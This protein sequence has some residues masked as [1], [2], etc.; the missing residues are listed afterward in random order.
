[1]SSGATGRGAAAAWENVEVV[2]AD[3]TVT[4]VVTRAHLRAHNLCHRCVYIAVLDGDDQLVVHQRAPWKDVWPSRW[5][6]AFGGV[7]GVGETWEAAARRELAEEAGLDGPLERLGRGSYAD[8]E[9]QVL[10]EAYLARSNGPFRFDDG[11]VVAV[12]RIA[13][14]E[15]GR[16][17]DGHPTCPDS[18]AVVLPL[19]AV[20][21]Q[22]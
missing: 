18:V 16:W 20:S 11:E 8:A 21:G 12:D 3:G 14:A 6:V 7:V 15:L 4:A 13:L 9:V 10:G 22:D 2:A 5:D 17:L 19:L 1:M